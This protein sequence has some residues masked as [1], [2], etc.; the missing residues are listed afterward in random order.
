MFKK[1]VLLSL[2]GLFVVSGAYYARGEMPNIDGVWSKYKL[3]GN[4]GWVETFE[5]KIEGGS[6]KRR[7]L[8]HP[9]LPTD[10]SFRSWYTNSFEFEGNKFKQGTFG[11]S[12]AP[13][14]DWQLMVVNSNMMIEEYD[15]GG[16]HYSFEIKRE[17]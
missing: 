1:F 10:T 16:M 11:T 13:V 15:A 14:L 7:M 5:L 8:K 4:R 6:I 17:R 9:F 2:V 12:D 3:F